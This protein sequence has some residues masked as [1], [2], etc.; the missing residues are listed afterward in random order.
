MLAFEQA[1]RKT[2]MD[3]LKEQAS[4]MDNTPS[5]RLG[6]TQV[7]GLPVAPRSTATDCASCA[8]RIGFPL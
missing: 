2:F 1:K 7:S 8:R 6:A 3:Q 5:F 4:R